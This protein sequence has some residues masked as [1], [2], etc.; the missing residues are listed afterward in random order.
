MTERVVDVDVV[1]VVKRNLPLTG[2]P[3]IMIFPSSRYLMSALSFVTL[4]L[5]AAELTSIEVWRARE[6]RFPT[7]NG[8]DGAAGK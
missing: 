8:R 5:V 3:K 1:V 6:D 2:H 7:V 4:T